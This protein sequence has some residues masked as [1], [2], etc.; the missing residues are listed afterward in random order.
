[1]SLSEIIKQ[2]DEQIKA[3]AAKPRGNRRQGPDRRAADVP[4]DMDQRV[5]DRRTTRERRGLP[6]REDFANQEAYS[7][8][9]DRWAENQR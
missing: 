3:R 9:Y 1:M 5:A 2:V 8:A 6:R 4:V 7:K